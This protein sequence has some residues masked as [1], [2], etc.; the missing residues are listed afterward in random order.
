MIPSSLKLTIVVVIG[1]KEYCKL[2]NKFLNSFKKSP[3]PPLAD[4]ELKLEFHS[5]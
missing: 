5:L 2:K 3:T 4:L 1:P